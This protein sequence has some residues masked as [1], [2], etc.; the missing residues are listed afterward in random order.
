MT[1]ILINQTVHRLFLEQALR[2]TE[3]V[4]GDQFLVGELGLG[5]I[6]EA[7]KARL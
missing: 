4:N 7:L 6:T 2:V 1:P 3:Q 5:I